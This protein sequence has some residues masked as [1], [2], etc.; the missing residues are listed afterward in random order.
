MMFRNLFCCLAVLSLCAGAYASEVK[1]TSFNY[2]GSRTQT[3][4][5]CGQVVNREVNPLTII[6]VVSDPDYK[7][8]GQYATIAS[9]EGKFCIII[10]TFTGKANATL[11]EHSQKVTAQIK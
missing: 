6:D 10:N 11:R 1:I 2:T 5:L 7:S 8:P 3:A 9:K 4:E